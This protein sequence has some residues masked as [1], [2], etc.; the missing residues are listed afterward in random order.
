[1]K[2]DRAS[3][4]VIVARPVPVACTTE[5]KVARGRPAQMLFEL[6]EGLLDR[7]VVGE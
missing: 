7:V 6:G 4:E 1:M 3:V 5:V 2:K